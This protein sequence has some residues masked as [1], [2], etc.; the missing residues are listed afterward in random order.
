MIVL[1]K[2]AP[3]IVAAVMLANCQSRK[4]NDVAPKSVQTVVD[5]SA[6]AYSALRAAVFTCG[7]Y[8]GGYCTDFVTMKFNEIVSPSKRDWTGNANKYFDNAK[9]KDWA[10]STDVSKGEGGA[11]ACWSGGGFGHVGFC[12][13]NYKKR[14]EKNTKGK[15]IKTWYIT[16]DEFN[17]GLF[18]TGATTAETACYTNN[19]I[20]TNYGVKTTAQI[21]SAQLAHGNYTFIGYIFPRKIK[22]K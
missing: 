19:A 18:K 17:W 9:A 7:P 2:I 10:T 5:S 4:N 1:K 22:K 13:D 11:I 21:E 15:V 3:F 8:S 16:I 20:T 14:E 6:V 12:V